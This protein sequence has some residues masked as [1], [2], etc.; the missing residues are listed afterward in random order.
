MRSICALVMV[1]AV[2]SSAGAD[3]SKAW[4]AAKDNLP[5][6]IPAIG[7]VD[8]AAVVKQPAFGKLLALVKKED[9]GVREGIELVKSAC[10][11]DLT[12]VVDG[13]VVAGDP[14]GK[15][16]D[17]MVFLQL[18]IDRP[19]ASTCLEAMLRT[20]EKRKQVTV[21]Q[22]GKFTEASVG[23]ET[24]YFAWVD[25]AVVAFNVEPIKKARLERFVG[26][27]GL[28]KSP[29]GS[30]FGK[31]DPKAAAFGA[32]KLAKPLDRDL[33]FTQV[34]GNATLTGT[35]LAGAIVGTATDAAAAGK[36][37]TE[38]KRELIKLALRDKLPAIAKKLV[39][40]VT[41]NAVGA[42]VTLKGSAATGDL[43]EAIMEMAVRKPAM[44]ADP[45]PAE[46][47]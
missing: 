33:P 47:P 22:T 8:V 17:I 46:A 16:D 34:Y 35:T 44:P 20:V 30:L 43:V 23:D 39:T 4:Q 26:K 21:Q 45:P 7:A 11:L 37:V 15:D 13:V 40:A 1:A 29:V 25:K 2:S 36:F 14:D 10:N 38:A 32:I 41:L 19:K 6:T 42:E 31:L 9:R 18:K 3:V 12:Q 5:D 28:A 24:A 27:Q